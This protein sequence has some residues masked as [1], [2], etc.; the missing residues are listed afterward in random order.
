MLLAARGLRGSRS[1]FQF[2]QVALDHWSNLGG[3][4]GQRFGHDSFLCKRSRGN[5]VISLR[6]ILL[7]MFLDRSGL[8]IGPCH[9]HFFLP[10]WENGRRVGNSPKSRKMK[11]L[12]MAYSI[13]ENVPTARESIFELCPASQCPYRAKKCF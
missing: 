3:M 11:V 6:I 5:S 4:L 2:E 7:R 9:G 12:R 13:V 1:M 10:S 8:I